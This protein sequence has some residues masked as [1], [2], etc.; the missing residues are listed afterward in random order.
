MYYNSSVALLGNHLET[1]N[2]KI[3]QCDYEVKSQFH[4]H[5][6]ILLR[7][8]ADINIFNTNYGKYWK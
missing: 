3:D 8:V 1:R 5:L 2:S 6:R 7:Q 4:G